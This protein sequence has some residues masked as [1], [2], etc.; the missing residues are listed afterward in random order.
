MNTD[1]LRTAESKDGRVFVAISYRQLW[2][3]SI[4]ELH[5]LGE[6]SDGLIKTRMRC[7]DAADAQGWLSLGGDEIVAEIGRRAPRL[8]QMKD[9]RTVR[10]PIYDDTIV[11][12]DTPPS[13]VESYGPPVDDDE[14]VDA[15]KDAKYRDA[16]SIGDDIARSVEKESKE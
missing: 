8:I 14:A 16:S 6:V 3:G 9:G 2:S 5:Y 11:L 4:I 15:S 13:A 12:S 1:A 10:T 7:F